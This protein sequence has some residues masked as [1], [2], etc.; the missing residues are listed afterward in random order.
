MNEWKKEKERKKNLSSLQI[1]TYKLHKVIHHSIMS[2]Y[3]LSL[4]WVKRK[5]LNHHLLEFWRNDTTGSSILSYVLM[6]S[7]YLQLKTVRDRV[8]IKI[9]FESDMVSDL[10][11]LVLER[12]RMNEIDFGLQHQMLQMQVAFFFV[13]LFFV[14][15]FYSPLHSYFQI[16]A[17]LSL[18]SFFFPPRSF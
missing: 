17:F 14:C 12:E 9:S 1:A 8:Q 6:F 2:A 4:F 10:L 5:L 13:C 16:L 3:S 18:F 11:F 7:K 15:L